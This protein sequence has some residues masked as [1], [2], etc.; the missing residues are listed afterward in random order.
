MYRTAVVRVE[1]G[2]CSSHF[3]ESVAPITEAALSVQQEV[4]NFDREKFSSTKAR[5]LLAPA[6]LLFQLLKSKSE[7]KLGDYARNLCVF[8]Y[9]DDVYAQ[10]SF[11]GNFPRPTDTISVFEEPRADELFLKKALYFC[12]ILTDDRHTAYFTHL[13]QLAAVDIRKVTSEKVEFLSVFQYRYVLDAIKAWTTY[14][15]LYPQA[16]TTISNITGMFV[17]KKAQMWRWVTTTYSLLCNELT[18][19]TQRFVKERGPNACIVDGKHFSKDYLLELYHDNQREFDSVT[20]SLRRYFGN[21]LTVEN[22]ADRLVNDRSVNLAENPRSRKSSFQNLF[23]AAVLADVAPCAER[24]TSPDEDKD[25]IHLVNLCARAVMWM[26]YAGAGGPYRFPEIQKLKYASNDRDLYADSESRCIEIHAGYS[27]AQILRP[28][29]KQLDKNTSDYLLFYTM[30]VVPI[31]NHVAGPGLFRRV[32]SRDLA[33]EMGMRVEEH[34]ANAADGEGCRLSDADFTTQVLNSYLFADLS[35]GKLLKYANFAK[36]ARKFPV[37]VPQDQRLSL[38]DLRHGIIYFMRRH[39]NVGRI[40]AGSDAVERLAGHTAATG[41]TVYAVPDSVVNHEAEICMAWHR[42]LDLAVSGQVVAVKDGDNARPDFHSSGSINDLLAAGRRL[43]SKDIFMFRKGQ[44]DV[45]TEVYLGGAQLIPV[46]AL[47]GFGKTALFQIPLIALK[48]TRPIPKVVSFVFVP[49]IPLKANMIDRLGTNGLLEVGDVAV[50]LKNGPN[51]DEDALSADVYVG[52]FHDMATVSCARLLDN[53]YQ[54]F[55]DTVLGLIVIDEFHNFETE[56][57]FRGNTFSAIGEINL[58]QAWKVLVLSGTVGVGGFNGPLQRLGYDESLTTEAGLDLKYFFFN[59]VDELPLGNSV[60]WFD[61]CAS[62]KIC[63]EKAVAMVDR[64]VAEEESAKVILVCRTREHAKILAVD[65]AK[66]RPLCVHGELTGAS[67]EQTMRSFIQDPV[68]RVLIGTKLVSEGIDVQDL[69]LVLLVDYLPSIGEY[70]QMAGRLRKGGLCAVLWSSGSSFGDQGELRPGCLTPQLNRFYGLS[71]HGHVGCCRAVDNCD[72]DSVAFVRRVFPGI[73]KYEK[74]LDSQLKRFSGTSSP[75]S[76]AQKRPLLVADSVKDNSTTRESV[77]N[78]SNPRDSARSLPTVDTSIDTSMDSTMELLCDDGEFLAS[79]AKRPAE[80][81]RSP[82]TPSCSN[83]DAPK[84]LLV[85]PGQSIV[86]LAAVRSGVRNVQPT[87]SVAPPVVSRTPMRRKNGFPESFRA[88]ARPVSQRSVGERLRE[89][90]GADLSLFHFLGVAVKYIPTL[91]FFQVCEATF[92]LSKA[93]EPWYCFVCMGAL[94]FKCVCE[95]FR[96][97]RNKYVVRNLVMNAL[98][99]LKIVASSTEW[100]HVVRMGD[101]G[102]FPRVP[103]W[104]AER[105]ADM[106]ARFRTRLLEYCKLAREM[107]TESD[108]TLPYPFKEVDTRGALQRYNRCWEYLRENKLDIIAFFATND[109]S[110]TFPELWESPTVAR[111]GS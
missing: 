69:L 99:F 94:A 74:V 14:A 108:F 110:T 5:F 27:K 50:L 72:P 54:T 68:K 55:R 19:T 16:T 1:K 24:T 49:Y 7:S 97:H 25:I 45:A 64:F 93:T 105:G 96:G 48:K 41:R 100:A 43:Y 39:T 52:A 71:Q 20:E 58:R 15:A 59:L 47:P 51:V 77:E 75:K 30:I 38:R 11:A 106:Q 28:V 60:K 83:V 6:S 40:V 42:F 82:T 66:H 84:Q 67:K 85:V 103:L 29:T 90:F 56:M 12:E 76:S 26:I 9:L 111:L 63:L 36:G 4:S 2:N 35:C 81:M 78:E 34:T 102:D 104:L 31:R 98:C 109:T 22:V 46:Q 32:M 79:P 33:D 44:K 37:S 89:A 92:G 57:A 95:D 10:F 86:Q 62:S 107:Y 91:R 65:L 53:W 61:E 88:A 70:V 87:F 21:I 18:Q 23:G 3:N 13:C 17:E 80:Q 73:L 101:D 8:I